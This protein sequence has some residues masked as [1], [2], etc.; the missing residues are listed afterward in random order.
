MPSCICPFSILRER[1]IAAR[2]GYT[3]IAPYGMIRLAPVSGWFR[4]L[5]WT[6]IWS[7]LP[8]KA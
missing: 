3:F 4:W 7:S 2:Y 5:A 1:S 8:V 6:A